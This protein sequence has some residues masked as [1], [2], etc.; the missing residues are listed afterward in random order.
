[1]QV[2]SEAHYD[3]AQP[4]FSA[5]NYKKFSKKQ[6]KKGCLSEEKQPW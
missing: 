3:G 2:L 6:I 4:N 5:K 1:M